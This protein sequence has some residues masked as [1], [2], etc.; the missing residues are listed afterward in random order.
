MGSTRQD[1]G[2]AAAMPPASIPAPH[3]GLLETA[4]EGA[5]V[6]HSNHPAD[7]HIH[8]MTR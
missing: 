5:A 4:L 6:L 1:A 8:H 2:D 7:V 3:L